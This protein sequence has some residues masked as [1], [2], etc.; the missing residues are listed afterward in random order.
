MAQTPYDNF[1]QKLRDAG[2]NVVEYNYPRLANGQHLRLLDMH[3]QDGR[4]MPKC[5]IYDMGEDGYRIFTERSGRSIDDDVLALTTSAEG[6]ANLN[7]GTGG[8]EN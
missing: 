1:K 7:L 2:V 3:D 4:P 5:M 8:A 6:Q